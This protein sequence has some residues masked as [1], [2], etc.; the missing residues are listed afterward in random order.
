MSPDTVVMMSLGLGMNYVQI[1]RTPTTA[2]VTVNTKLTNVES[3]AIEVGSVLCNG[4]PTSP[5]T[6]LSIIRL[7]F[8]AGGIMVN[9]EIVN[10]DTTGAVIVLAPIAR[11]SVSVSPNAVVLSIA[12]LII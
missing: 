9:P 6:P 10:P 7:T 2:T 12:E 3:N 1:K 11:V 5:V 8:P 4:T